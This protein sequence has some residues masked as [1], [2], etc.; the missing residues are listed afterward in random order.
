[1]CQV[2]LS[3]GWLIVRSIGGEHLLNSPNLNSIEYL[4]REL[5]EY[6]YLEVKP[7]NKEALGNG[8][9]SFWRTVTEEKCK[10]YI[11]HLRNAICHV[12]EL[13]EPATGY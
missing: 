5:K 11:N 12:I 6:M 3:I 4:S 7:L 1:M 8:I 10:K 13:E 9:L 2:I